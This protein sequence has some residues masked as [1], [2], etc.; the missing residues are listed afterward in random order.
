LK[1]DEPEDIRQLR[2]NTLVEELNEIRRD[3]LREFSEIMKQG[4]SM[5]HSTNAE[6][7]RIKDSQEVAVYVHENLIPQYPSF[8]HCDFEAKEGAMEFSRYC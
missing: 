7:K 4:A 5:R 8:A 6:S 1:D 3:W 2:E